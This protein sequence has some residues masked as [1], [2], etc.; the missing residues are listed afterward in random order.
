MRELTV[1]DYP[2]DRV[3]QPIFIKIPARHPFDTRLV[4][5]GHTELKTGLIL[6]ITRPDHLGTNV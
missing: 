2:F 6:K 5:A 4:L 3:T 1:N